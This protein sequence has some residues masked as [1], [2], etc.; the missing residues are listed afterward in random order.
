MLF[1]AILAATADLHAQEIPFARRYD[2]VIYDKVHING[3]PTSGGKPQ[4]ITRHVSDATTHRWFEYHY[5][6][7]ILQVGDDGSFYGFDLRTRAFTWRYGANTVRVGDPVI[8]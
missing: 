4:K 6:A 5:G 7:S 8:P 3:V 1:A 2:S